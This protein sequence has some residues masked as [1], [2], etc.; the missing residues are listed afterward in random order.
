MACEW[1]IWPISGLRDLIPPDLSCWLPLA[2]AHLQLI[3]IVLVVPVAHFSSGCPGSSTPNA[4]L[5]RPADVLTRPF[6]R[7]HRAHS[8]TGPS[9]RAQSSHHDFPWDLSYKLWPWPVLLSNFG[10]SVAML[11]H[12][13]GCLLKVSYVCVNTDKYM[14]WKHVLQMCLVM[15][16]HRLITNVWCLEYDS[17]CVCANWPEQA[18]VLLIVVGGD[19]DGRFIVLDELEELG[20][21]QLRVPVIIVLR[22]GGKTR[23]RRGQF[24]NS[25]AWCLL[26]HWLV[27]IG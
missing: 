3:L 25:C 2:V 10:N 23:E 12:W 11:Y 26:T 15:C 20:G 21:V 13:A 9:L 7:A 27:T 6:L 17:V 24:S 1:P 16:V 19:V 8:R 5:V 22:G 4:N 18:I 14:F